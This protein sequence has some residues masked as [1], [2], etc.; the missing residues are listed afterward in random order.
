LSARESG[1]LLNLLLNWLIRKGVRQKSTLLER[2]LID[3]EEISSAIGIIGV[4][5][6][7]EDF[8]NLLGGLTRLCNLCR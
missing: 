5:G 2:K 7:I 4:I 3:M 6:I 1:D 8:W